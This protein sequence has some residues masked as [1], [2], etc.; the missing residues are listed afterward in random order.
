MRKFMFFVLGLF[1]FSNLCFARSIDTVPI[2]NSSDS[3]DISCASTV[4][5]YSKSFL[6]GDAEYF[7]FDYWA[8]CATG[9]T[10]V[11]IELEQSNVLPAA[12]G[13]ADSNYVVPYV[14][15]TAQ[16][17]II[18]ALTTESTWYSTAYSPVAK[19]YGRL[20]IT[21]T[22]SDASATLVKASSNKQID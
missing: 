11:K 9:T 17:D 15:G 21:A 2:T 4:A 1:I 8:Y 13:A 18:T 16:P 5:T 6:I 10:S 20:K 3:T 19:K 7:S 12:E 14:S 22:S